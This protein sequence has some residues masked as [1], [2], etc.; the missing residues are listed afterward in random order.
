MNTLFASV[1]E[2]LSIVEQTDTQLVLRELPLLDWLV[3]GAI[4][5]TALQ[6]MLF[7]FRITAV[8]AVAIAAIFAIRART[9]LISFDAE[10]NLMQV[11][12]QSLLRTQ[13]IEEIGL[14]QISRAY[15]HKDDTGQS[16][17]ILVTALGDEMGL[18]AYSNDMNDWKSPIV[19]AINT[20]LHE[21]HQDDGDTGTI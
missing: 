13:V 12:Y 6:F 11:R 21:A 18:S 9:R 20:L 1:L 8:V 7:D 3:A 4:F 10:T 19:V 17:I 16:Q 14:H 15:L 2:K 5:I